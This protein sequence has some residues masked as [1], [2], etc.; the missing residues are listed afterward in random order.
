MVIDD[1]V[2]RSRVEVVSGVMLGSG[3]GFRH[4]YDGW[5]SFRGVDLGTQ[6]L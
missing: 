4:V 6:G 3:L 2:D 5:L 1:T